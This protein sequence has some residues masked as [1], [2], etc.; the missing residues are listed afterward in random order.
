M[1]ILCGFGPYGKYTTNL[2]SEIVKKLQFDNNKLQIV[3]KIIPVSWK[4]SIETYKRILSNL[5]S[6]PEL[7][8]LLGIHS[9][10]KIHLEKFGW[11]FKFGDDIEK[12]FKFG[13]IKISS[14]LWIKTLLNLNKI[15]SN[16]EKKSGISISYFPG[17]YLCNYLYFWALYLSKKEYPVVFIHI[18][19]RADIFECIKKVEIILKV[20]TKAYIK[21]IL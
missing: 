12:K 13:P 10:T 21:K 18:P 4:Q 5:N 6:T 15:Y 1:I 17:L 16:L 9:N 19:R 14:F 8:I 20:I 11:N 3:R 7:V 2:S